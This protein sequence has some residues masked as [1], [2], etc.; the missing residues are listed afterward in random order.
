MRG[1]RK[2]VGGKEVGERE[3]GGEHT[4]THTHTHTCR[5]KNINQSETLFLAEFGQPL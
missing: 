1:G 3:G 2:G 5:L 4:H